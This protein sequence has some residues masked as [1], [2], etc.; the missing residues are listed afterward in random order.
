MQFL[1]ICNNMFTRADRYNQVTTTFLLSYFL[2]LFSIHSF[3]PFLPLPPSFPHSIIPSILPSL[4]FP[5][6]HPSFPPS[7]SPTIFPFLPPSLSP[8]FSTLSFSLL[9]FLPPS[10]P[11]FLSLPSHQFSLYLIHCNCVNIMIHYI[12]AN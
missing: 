2:F 9:L 4:N 11:Y 8:S 6:L 5:S 3:I 1:S 7:S 10:L 12:L